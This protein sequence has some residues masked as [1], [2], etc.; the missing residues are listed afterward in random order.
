M[1]VQDTGVGI[2]E[3]HRKKLF[4]SEG[5]VRTRGTDGETGTGLGLY[6]CR[7][8]VEKNNGKIWVKSRTGQGSSFYLTLPAE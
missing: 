7:Q 5:T 3:S 1:E 2:P 8:F 6:L 4:S